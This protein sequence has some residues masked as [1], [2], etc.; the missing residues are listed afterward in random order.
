MRNDEWRAT[1]E[2]PRIEESDNSQRDGRLERKGKGK[3]ST[4][5]RNC[6]KMKCRN[7]DHF[8]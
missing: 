7:R 6:V 2:S 1:T 4:T 3:D 5:G 8:A